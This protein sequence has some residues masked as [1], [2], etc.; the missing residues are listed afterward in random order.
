MKQIKTF[1]GMKIIYQNFYHTYQIKPKYLE[2]W[3]GK[4]VNGF[5]MKTMKINFKL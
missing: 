4:I 3:K 5:G 2:I 1:L